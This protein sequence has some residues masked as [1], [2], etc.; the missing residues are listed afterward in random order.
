MAAVPV[1]IQCMVYPRDKSGRP[2]PATLVGFASITGLTVGGGPVVP[3]APP[4]IKPEPPL[5]I[6]GGPIDPYPDI[7][8]PG[9]QPPWPIDPPPDEIPPPTPPHE[10]WNWSAVNSGWYYL[11]VPGPGAAGPKRG[12]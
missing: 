5:V 4:D 10:G 12:R 8:G 2:Y 7:G 11:Y 1:T 6:W 9:P 3:E